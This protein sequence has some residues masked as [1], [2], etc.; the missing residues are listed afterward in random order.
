MASL[1]WVGI[2]WARELSSTFLV[3]L[4]PEN[5]TQ[6][7]FLFS[8]GEFLVGLRGACI[9]LALGGVGGYKYAVKELFVWIFINIDKQVGRHSLQT[10]LSF[11]RFFLQD[12]HTYT[13][14]L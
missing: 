10:S 11:F 14:T 3:E 4:L 7:E 6:G 8:A 13:H 1:R 9:P 5:T 12:I 2:L